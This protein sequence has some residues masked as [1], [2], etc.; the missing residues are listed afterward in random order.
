[1]PEAGTPH[2]WLVDLQTKG[3]AD[4]IRQLREHA[5]DVTLIACG[6]P[7]SAA[8]RDAAQMD[9]Y[10]VVDVESQNSE[11]Q[12][13]VS[14]AAERADLLRALSD[15]RHAN[16]E[17]A[18]RP[19]TPRAS[20]EQA[21]RPAA[22]WPAA[23]RSFD[24]VGAALRA[25]VEGI[26]QWAQVTR[27]GLFGRSEQRPNHFVLRAALRP[28]AGTDQWS[29]GR[30]DAIPRWLERSLQFVARPHLHRIADANL[31]DLLAQAMDDWGAEVIMPL[32]LHTE[33]AGWLFL[34]PRLTGLPFDD[35]ALAEL[36][37]VADYA[38]TVLDNALQYETASVQRTLLETV[39]QTMP[40]GVV[41]VDANGVVQKYNEAAR[42]IFGLAADQVVNQPMETLSEPLAELLRAALKG[43]VPKDAHEWTDAATRRHLAGH[44]R[45][46][47]VG[48]RPMGAVAFIHDHTVER[49]LASKQ[50]QIERAEF[51]T[52]LAAAMSHEVRNPL[53][54][55]KTFAQLLPERYL[56][57]EFRT[58]FA[59]TVSGEVGR[60]ENIIEQIHQFAHPP[61][62]VLSQVNIPRVIQKAL[63]IALSGSQSAGVWV[64]TAIAEDLPA[65]EGDETALAQCIA[66]LVANAAE[67]LH[68]RVNPK[69]VI[70]AQMSPPQKEASP[71]AVLITVQD[72][73]PG[74]PPEIR[75]KVFS[76]FC[77]TKA[78]GLGLG[79][80]IAKRIVVDHG[81]QLDI[82]TTDRGTRVFIRLPACSA[83]S[84]N[85]KYPGHA[86]RPK[87]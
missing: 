50:E 18:P 74:I 62:L 60:L 58:E 64:E 48:G 67:A 55:I 68:G 87:N 39:L 81:G 36:A 40:T 25:L 72:N 69:V 9:V 14:R 66:H 5:P 23:L 47:A 7:G 51:W 73:G 37:P 70:S 15:L 84:R 3:Y 35:H 76:P 43:D 34:G 80:P 20:G 86:A 56:D 49:L 52:G 8:W 12:H 54:A 22:T 42:A 26:A 1:M 31:R 59:Q 10:C 29:A 27:A 57:K 71:P 30:D 82:E 6:I 75:P 2:L 61:P 85:T 28:L 17:H 16:S 79:L 24:D 33:L 77:T 38:A 83:T 78:R 41:V 4:I 32:Q 21:F 53:V 44:A 13:I 63:D 65:V 11:W 45:P 19:A 46:L